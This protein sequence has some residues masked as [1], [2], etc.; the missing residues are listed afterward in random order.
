V[1]YWDA[2]RTMDNAI[3]RVKNSKS[4]QGD[5][6]PDTEPYDR[7]QLVD[8]RRAAKHALLLTPAPG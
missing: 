8:Y 3:S 7:R 5:L 2:R 1:E 4:A 6:H